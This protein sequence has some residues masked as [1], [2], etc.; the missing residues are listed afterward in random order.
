MSLV[1]LLAGCSAFQQSKVGKATTGA[2]STGVSAKSASNEPPPAQREFRAAWVATV[3]NIDWPS[4]P[5]LST[6]EQQKEILQILERAQQC[7]LNAIV[8][9][10]RTSCDA[11]YDSKIEPWS[12]Y[13]TGKQGKAP[14]PYYDPLKFWVD[15]CHKRGIELHAWFNPFR[16]KAGKGREDRSANHVSKTKPQLVKDY[17]P[18][19]WLDPGQQEA[20]DQTFNVFMDVVE[21]YDVDGIHI[22]DY[23][24]P[25][26][27][28]VNEKDED[29]TREV[30]FPDNDSYKKYQ[31]SGGKLERDDWRRQNIDKM[32]HRIYEGIHQRKNWVQYG[33]SPFGIP[34]PGKPEYVKGFD[35]YAKLYADAE[36]WM[37][38]G[39]LD[40]MVP[41]LYW[42]IGAPQ[43]PY[44]GL[45]Q[46]WVDNNPKKRHVYAGLFTSRIDWS[47]RSW[48]PNEIA[49]QI[50]ISKLVQ[51][52]SGGNVHFSM[53]A[54][55]QNRRGIAD[56][57]RS[58]VY[59][60]D[61]LVPATT[62]LDKK[63]PA[64]PTSVAA[65]K[66]APDKVQA[67]MKWD[68]ITTRPAEAKED[69]SHGAT[70]PATTSATTRGG[71][72]GGAATRP[73]MPLATQPTKAVDKLKKLG[74]T[75]VTWKAGS[76]ENVWQY[77]VYAKQGDTWTMKVVPGNKTE[78]IFRD[79]SDE[80]S[81]TTAVAVAAVDRSGNES[82]RSIHVISS[83]G[84]K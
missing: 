81:P 17:G 44:L 24:Y 9:Q 51:P 55:T 18:Y 32:M 62:W 20:Q 43:Q 73:F 7:R 35:Q 34:R 40:Y 27:V 79:S 29:D 41:Q 11:L 31:E 47:E 67:A 52:N 3:G 37:K 25:Y 77:A 50:M 76:D 19:L 45:L 75:R 46:W 21:R 10:V 23:F 60:T 84:K 15:E 74:G 63:P 49:G 70:T 8:L 65:E 33:I 82:A 64:K 42:S 54:L 39:W 80:K 59:A 4:K 12:E 61:A 66:V 26:P 16:A 57:L 68:Y 38:E 28:R 72:R 53:I 69:A 22:D 14:E 2:I 5:G 78:V 58:G 1:V 83:E 71:R 48:H 30:P 36:K 13:L 56:L 6:A